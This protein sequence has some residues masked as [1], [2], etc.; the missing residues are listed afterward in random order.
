[1]EDLTEREKNKNRW[2]VA[3]YYSK[4]EPTFHYFDNEATARDYAGYAIAHGA[5]HMVII[6]DRMEV[7]DEDF[8]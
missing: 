4:I 7:V 1:M 8:N 5:C 6:I 3:V 2:K